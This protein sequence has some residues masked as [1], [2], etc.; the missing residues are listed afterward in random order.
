MQS[1]LKDVWNETPIRKTITLNG[2]LQGVGNRLVGGRAWIVECPDDTLDSAIF[3]REECF[4]E[5][6]NHIPVLC[7]GRHIFGYSVTVSGTK[8]EA[9]ELD[10]E[11]ITVQVVDDQEVM[12]KFERK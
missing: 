6:L 7:G 12:V 3:L 10:P 8:T 5:L 11:V 2:I 1:R 9:N 4:V